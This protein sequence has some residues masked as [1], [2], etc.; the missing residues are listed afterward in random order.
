MHYNPATTIRINSNSPG[1]RAPGLSASGAG[2]VPQFSRPVANLVTGYS[3]AAT[4]APASSGGGF[5]GSGS[6]SHFSGGGSFHGSGS[7]S[8]F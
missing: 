1:L 5:S 7:S 4:Y 3:W 8:R 6:S 2:P